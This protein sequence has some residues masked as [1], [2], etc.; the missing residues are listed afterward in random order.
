MTPRRIAAVV[1][2]MDGTLIDSESIYRAALVQA[3]EALGRTVDEAFLHAITGLPGPEITLR[4]RA[5]YGEDFPF[6][7]FHRHY[8]ARRDTLAGDG[9]PLRPGAAEALRFVAGLGLP[10]AL[11]TSSMRASALGHLRRLEILAHFTAVVTRDDVVRSKPHPDLFLKAAALLGVAP[12]DCLAV[13]DS[14]AGVT[15][16]LAAGMMTVMVPDLV[17]PDAEMRRACVAVHG[18]LHELPLLFPPEDGA[19]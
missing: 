15:A 8:V 12:A 2:D 3:M 14:V 16:A 18:S 9:I 4:I 10:I 17:M 13:E 11:A 1:F 19:A 7:A 5:R 6:A